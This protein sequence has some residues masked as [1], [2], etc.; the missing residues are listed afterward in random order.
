MSLRPIDDA[1]SCAH[2]RAHVVL[3]RMRAPRGGREQ[4]VLKSAKSRE[5]GRGAEW[6]PGP[7]DLA[8]GPGV[9]PTWSVPASACGPTA[10]AAAAS[11]A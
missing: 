9:R 4:L 1:S 11:V 7:C 10:A 2:A 8:L 6:Q 3:L 5:G